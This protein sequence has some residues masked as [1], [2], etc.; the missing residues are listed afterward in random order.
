MNPDLSAFLEHARSKG[1]DHGTI[2]MLLLSAGWKEKDVARALAAHALEMPVP[3]P[4]DTG[5]ARD[6]FLHLTAFAALYAS[7]I[8]GVSLLFAY[9]NRLLPDPAFREQARYAAAALSGMRWSLA[10][11]VV[12]FPAFLLLSRFLLR[13]VRREPE[14]AWSAVRRWLTYLTLFVAAVTLAVDFITLVYFFLEGDISVRFLVKVAI[15]GAIAALAFRYYLA[16]VRMPAREL[17]ASRLHRGYGAI[18]AA[19]AAVTVVGG[20]AFVGSPVSERLRKLDGQR[21]E[22]LRGIRSAADRYCLGP[23]ARRPDGAPPVMVNPIPA[24]LDELARLAVEERPNVADPATGEPYG[25][26]VTGD[27]SFEVCATFDAPRDEPF[28]VEWNHPAGRACFT[29]DLVKPK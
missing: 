7:A 15:V 5:G 1:M 23:N 3:A 27:S 13:E 21:V 6:A 26:R 10:V 17:A 16:A 22:D 2:R 24:S 8:A 20:I 12:A 4:P 9:V 11:L 19:I 25:W 28:E 14:R 29:F 18:A